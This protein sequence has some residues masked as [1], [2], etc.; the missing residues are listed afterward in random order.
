MKLDF[1]PVWNRN[2]T[3]PWLRDDYHRWLVRYLWKSRL[4][5]DINVFVLLMFHSAFPVNVRYG[6]S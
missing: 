3:V 2:S 1:D 4:F 6:E 5:E